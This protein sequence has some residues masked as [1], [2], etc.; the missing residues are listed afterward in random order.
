LKYPRPP[1]ISAA[2]WRTKILAKFD[3]L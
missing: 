2:V 1:S 3:E